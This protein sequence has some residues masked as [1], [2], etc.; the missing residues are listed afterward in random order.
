MPSDQPEN[1]RTR[2][3]IAVLTGLPEGS[4]V[5]YGGVASAAGHPKQARLVGHVLAQYSDRLGLPWWRVV[6]AQGRLV[7]GSER[8]QNRLLRLEGVT[9][10]NGRAPISN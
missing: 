9:V 8:E 2:D 6:N 4:V 7:P 10:V 1:Q 5:T 3:I